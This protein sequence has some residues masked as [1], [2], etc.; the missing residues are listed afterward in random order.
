MRISPSCWK[1]LLKPLIP[2]CPPDLAK[3]LYTLAQRTVFTRLQGCSSSMMRTR[4]YWIS[5][6]TA[7]TEI[8]KR[9][10]ERF[11]KEF[12]AESTRLRSESN[13]G[14]LSSKEK[15]DLLRENKR[16]CERVQKVEPGLAGFRNV[17]LH[18][19]FLKNPLPNVLKREQEALAEKIETL[20][21]MVEK[22][23]E[24]HLRKW[25]R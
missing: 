14:K 25:T 22:V 8:A 4:M 12:K 19:I 13:S 15:M 3:A 20:T 16:L 9:D 7:M 10:P 6:I 17:K 18:S 11:Y 1:T 5:L 2:I 21:R 23:E 24:D